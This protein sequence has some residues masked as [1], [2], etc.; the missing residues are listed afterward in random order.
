MNIAADDAEGQ[1]R[2]A[3]FV[4]DLRQLGW[5]DWRNV[6][7]DYRFAGQRATP[8]SFADMPTSFWRSR[9]TPFWPQLPQ[10]FNLARTLRSNWRAP[11]VPPSAQLDEEEKSYGRWPLALK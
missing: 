11:I 2:L 4:Q 6:R 7:I 9:R 10:A 8:V 5:T 1:A 3:A